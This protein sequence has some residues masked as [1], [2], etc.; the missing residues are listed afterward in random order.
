[1]S[2]LIKKSGIL[3]TVQDLGRIGWR[4]FGVNPNGAMDPLAAR[5]ANILAGNSD[6]APLL[7]MHFPAAEIEFEEDTIFALSGGDF[8]AAVSG[9][10][11]PNWRAVAAKAGSVLKFKRK[12]SGERC[13]LSVGGGIDVLSWL[14]S[15]STNLTARIGGHEGRKLLS[16]DRLKVA[17]VNARSPCEKLPAIA[18]TFLPKYGRFPTVRILPGAEFEYLSAESRDSLLSET[19]AI[20]NNSNR[21]G[22]RLSGAPLKLD[23]AREIVSAAV[24]FG[25]VQLLPDGQLIILMADQ[26]TAGGYP[27]VAHIIS[28]DLPLVGQ[29]GAGDKIAFH[30]I[31][32]EAAEQLAL[33][34]E[35]ELS[36]LRVAC[37]LAY[38]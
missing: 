31:E 32:L 10:V 13:Y 26:Q 7:E 8:G 17:H 1:M 23:K 30:L 35:K 2:L 12:T 27:R 4:R 14:G 37:R 25:T 29:L 3:T 34:L 20:S 22:F 38:R 19:F 28:Y 21:M 11:L 9:E 36:F 33:Q 15:A 6:S 18:P 24:C 16:G 5:V